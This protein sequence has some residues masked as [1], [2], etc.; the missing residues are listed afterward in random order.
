MFE[1]IV[2]SLL[3][4]P[5]LNLF[6]ALVAW[7]IW[8]SYRRTARSLLIISATSLYA[9]ST[10]SISQSLAALLPENEP[11]SLYE[12]KQ[13]HASNYSTEDIPQII[14]VGAGR[15]KKAPEYEFTDTVNQKTLELLRYSAYLHKKTNLPLAVMSG[16]N[17]KGATA[18]AVLMNQVLLDDFA[19][20]S[21]ALYPKFDSKILSAEVGNIVI[22]DAM[23]VQ[24]KKNMIALLPKLESDKYQFLPYAEVL[25]LNHAIVWQWM[26]H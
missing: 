24:L 8:K 14:V 18:E 9:F 22:A 23:T 17:D 4:P 5:G 11:P 6:L 2:G 26:F 21:S 19:L 16:P 25:S 13:M 10:P 3:L 20:N 15:K 12:I 7:V 1:E